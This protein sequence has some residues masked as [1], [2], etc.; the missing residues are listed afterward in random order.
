MRSSRPSERAD[1]FEVDLSHV[2]VVGR[3]ADV[4]RPPRRRMSEHLPRPAVGRPCGAARRARPMPSS[5]GSRSACPIRRPGPAAGCA[6]AP[7]AIRARS[8]RLAR[9]AAHHDF[10]LDGPMLPAGS[11]LRGRGRGRRRRHARTTARATRRRTEAAVRRC[12]RRRGADRCWAATTRSR[13]RSLRAFADRGPLTVVQVDAHLD[14]RDEVAGV[15]DGYSSPMR[16]AS[17]MG[18]VE[19]IVQVGLRGVGSARTGGRGRCPGRGQPA[20]HRA[21][22]GRARGAVAARAAAGRRSGRPGLRPG[23]AGSVGGAGGERHRAGRARPTPQARGP[24]AGSD[25][26]HPGGR[27]RLHRDGARARRQ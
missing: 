16:R 5:W 14:F 21:R 18:H 1:G 10:D 3:C 27:R 6:E 17:E 9:F 25:R 19:R 13:S 4:R 8:Q 26:P 24:A 7:A 2:T 23:W 22:A 12:W 15:R 11:T 20:G